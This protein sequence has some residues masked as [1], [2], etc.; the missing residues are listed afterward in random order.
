MTMILYGECVSARSKAHVRICELADEG[1]D[2][3]TDAPQG[4][5]D[6]DFSLWIGAMG[7]FAATATQRNARRIAVRFKEPLD[8]KILRHFNAA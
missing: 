8:G 7:P 6:A 4:M 1:C 5:F 3:E 2:L